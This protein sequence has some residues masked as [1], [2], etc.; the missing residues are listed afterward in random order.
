MS[1]MREGVDDLVDT[2]HS[3][4]EVIV[5]DGHDEAIVGIVHEDRELE[6]PKVVYSKQKIIQT[7]ISRDEMSYD[8]AVE[9]YE[10]NIAGLYAGK[11]TPLLMDDPTFEICEPTQ[12]AGHSA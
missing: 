8:E 7:L 6:S 4:E 5:F 2:F 9:F 1:E 11:G 12:S 3:D 10:F